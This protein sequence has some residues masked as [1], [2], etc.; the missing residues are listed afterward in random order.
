MADRVYQWEGRLQSG[1]QTWLF[2]SMHARYTAVFRFSK[3]PGIIADKFEYCGV[4]S[5]MAVQPEWV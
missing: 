2:P 5:C 4:S 3:R 1:I